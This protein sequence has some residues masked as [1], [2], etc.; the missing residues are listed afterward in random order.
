VIKI[1]YIEDEADS[2]AIM[3]DFLK[4]LGYQRAFASTGN[5]GIEKAKIEKPD[6][7]FLDIKLPDMDGF[8]VCRLLKDNPELKQIPV[9]MVTALNSMEIME[10]SFDCGAVDVFEKPLNFKRLKKKIE[11]V[12]KNEKREE[13]KTEEK[14]ILV[15]DDEKAILKL[16]RFHLENS[17][18]VVFT[19]A[20]GR[21]GLKKVKDEKPDLV[22]TDVVM[23]KVS[24]LD[25]CKKIKKKPSGEQ[26][27]VIIFTGKMVANLEKGYE[28][29]ADACFTKPPDWRNLIKKMG[30]LLKKDE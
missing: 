27:P 16:A 13:M 26:I 18:Y 21:E 8:E 6:V 4:S 12:F 20:D 22:L 23:P 17:G 28:Y 29:G 14:K 19:A 11:K 3:E 5:D 25:V 24:G 15:I 1:L 9:I 7:I 2:Q 10:K 30:E